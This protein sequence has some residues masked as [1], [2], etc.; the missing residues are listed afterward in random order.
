MKA[1]YDLTKE[2]FKLAYENQQEAE[3]HNEPL[4]VSDIKLN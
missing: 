1:V 3:V 2:R 4:V